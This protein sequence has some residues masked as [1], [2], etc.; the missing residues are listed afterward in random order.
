[1][2]NY[3]QAM[4]ASPQNVTVLNNVAEALNALPQ[5]LRGST[6]L[7]KVMRVF[8]EQ[9]TIMQQSMVQ[10]GLYRWGSTWVDKLQMERLQEVEKDIQKKLDALAADFD[11]L[12]KKIDSLS[13][14]I[15]ANQ[16]T[17]TSMENASLVSDAKGNLFHTALPVRYYELER[18][19]RQ[20]AT[21][22]DAAGVKQTDLRAQAKLEQQKLPTPKYTA[23]QR[24]IGPEGTPLLPAMEDPN[25]V[26]AKPK[27]PEIQV[28]KGMNPLPASRSVGPP[29]P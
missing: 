27:P 5:N 8:T 29:V 26:K 9:D 10:S 25:A 20:M 18:D 4:L 12:Q 13:D 1:M 21:D 3:L 17:M 22:R 2:N 14:N 6:T 16:R 11:S 24:L 28:P 23:V 7:Q 15:N 19:N